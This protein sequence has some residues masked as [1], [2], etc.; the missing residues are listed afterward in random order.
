L[1]R[2]EFLTAG[3]G[4]VVFR[5][6]CD[7]AARVPAKGPLRVFPANPRY[8]TDGSGRAVYLSGAHTWANLQ[9]SGV[10]PVPRFNWSGYLDMMEQHNHNFMR[11]WTW[12]QA[13]W[14]PWTP[15]KILYEPV[16]YLRTGPG[17]AGDGAPKFDLTRFNPAFF[18]RMRAR[19]T[20][21]RDRGIYVSVMLFQGFSVKRARHCG[22]PWPAHPYNRQNNVSGFD[23]EK[24]GDSVVD[25][26]SPAVRQMHAAYLRKIVDTVNDLDNVLY[27]VINE[28]GE[29]DWDWFVVDTVHKLE[30]DKG[31]MHPVGLTG[32]GAER[33]EE[34]L[35]SS[36]EWISPGTRDNG[37][38]K[39]DPP[40]WDGRK[41]SVLDTDHLWGHG[42][43]APWVWKSF[44]RGYNTLLMD[45]W[46]PIAGRACPEV[47]WGPRP[48][49]PGRDLNRGDNT[50][51]E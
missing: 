11:L 16:A 8:F 23:G 6:L 31:R 43:T 5:S 41:V 22:D 34:M 25:L 42:G 17:T 50:R 7:G 1:R 28:G 45:S 39:S 40:A 29:R 44:L 10:A 51:C 18:D 49:Y 20:E 46:E 37:Y 2:R 9:D 30:R 38:Y 19:I 35:A 21:C 36:A 15:E 33:L 48:G 13:A 32:H 26:A 27:E 47:N 14:A 4:S 3:A 24:K 12:E